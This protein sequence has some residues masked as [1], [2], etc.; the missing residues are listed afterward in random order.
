[1]NAIGRF[2]RFVALGVLVAGPALGATRIDLNRDWLF[3][4]DPGPSGEAAGWQKQ[5][6]P[7]TEQVTVPHTWN[8]GKHH[9]YLGTGWYFRRFEMPPV[10]AGGRV[11]LHFGATFYAAHVWLNGV[12]IGRHEGGFT[13]YSFDITPQ[14]KATN[15]LAIAI[16]NRPGA[17]TIPGW[18]ARGEPEAWYDWWD[19]GGIV[20]DVWLTTGG[21]VQV[22]RQMIRSVVAADNAS[23]VVTDRVYLRSSGT[24]NAA[25]TVRATAFGPANTVEATDSRSITVEPGAADIAVSL[26]LTAPKLWGIDHPNVYRMVVEVV[27]NKGKGLDV[28]NDTFGVRRIEIRDRHLLINGERVRLTGMARHEDSPTEGL[29]ETAGTMR[30]DYDDMKAMHTT[31]SRPVHY[32]QNPFIL[33]YADRHGI[34]M[35][36]EIPLWQFSE[37]QLSNPKVVAL[38]KQQMGE[39]IAEAGNH[40]AVF[41][42]SALNESATATP[43]GI[44]YFRAM[45]EFIRKL[46]PERFVSYA[47]DNLPKLARAEDSAANDADFLMMNQYFGAWHGPASALE[48]SLDKV[49]RMFPDKM[50]II[51]EMGFPGIFAKNAVE[52]DEKR[53]KTLQ[54][55][56]PVLAK[57]D[58][59]AGAILWCYQDYKSRRNLWPGQ[60]EGFVEHGVVDENRQRKPSYA[61]WQE[62]NAAATIEAAWKDPAA[63]DAPEFTAKVTPKGEHD[64]PSYPMHDYRLTWQ[65]LDDKGKLI[66]G[67]EQKLPEFNTAQVISGGRPAGS[68]AHAVKLVVTVWRPTGAV[69]AQK[70]LERP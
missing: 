10:V 6:P 5:L 69:G 44:A 35:M 23:A 50:V 37:A 13:A 3:R 47:D 14:L 40:P 55:Q 48:P 68:D 26:K 16:D 22:D 60:E 39:M 63:S 34:L 33:D 8:V 24:R 27:D 9:D 19:Y 2:S 52:A 21:A 28:H 62:I 38:A 46:D 45:H 32:P 15:F 36:P 4:T 57:R 65:L 29:A 70:T 30:H 54:D 12:E 61:V 7:D 49:D 64:L 18:G 51:S 31:L 11:E 1:M 53:V 66:A 20:R 41:A 59:I 56:M 43:G 58:W 42:W 25:V 67:G 17:T